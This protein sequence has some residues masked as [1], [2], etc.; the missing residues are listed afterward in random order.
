MGIGVAYLLGRHERTSTSGLLARRL[1]IPRSAQDFR[2]GMPS[3]IMLFRTVSS[4]AL[5][6]PPASIVKEGG[7][8]FVFTVATEAAYLGSPSDPEAIRAQQIYLK[9]SKCR[10]LQKRLPQLPFGNLSAE[11]HIL[12]APRPKPRSSGFLC[13]EAHGGDI[14]LGRMEILVEPQGRFP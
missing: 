1:S 14:R 5:L 13:R 6:V 7:S 3:N 9:K 12:T 11:T 8:A 10:F 2:I 4:G